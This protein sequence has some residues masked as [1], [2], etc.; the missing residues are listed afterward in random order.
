MT[1][2]SWLVTGAIVA[3]LIVA[4]GF[5]AYRGLLA[6]AVASGTLPVDPVPLVVETQDGARS[7]SI[8]VADDPAERAQGLM[9]RRD[10]ADDHGMLFVFEETQQVG[11]WMK[12]TV[13]PLDLIFIGQDGRIRAILPGEPLSLT[14]IAP[15]EP[16]RYVFEVKRGIAARNGIRDGDLVRHPDIEARGSVGEGDNPG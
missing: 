2:R 10:M 1:R 4:A 9:Y 3:M 8:E 13:L 12:D 5:Y 6:P 14:P 15:D 16:V 11:F 7:F